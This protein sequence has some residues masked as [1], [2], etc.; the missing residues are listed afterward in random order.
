M[1]FSNYADFAGV[2]L[3]YS[4]S[5]AKMA[6]TDVVVI[7]YHIGCFGLDD[8]GATGR[9]IIVSHHPAPTRSESAWRGLRSLAG[10]TKRW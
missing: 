1:L 2:L 4:N 10:S 5:G 3:E 8:F 6:G 9:H 7:G